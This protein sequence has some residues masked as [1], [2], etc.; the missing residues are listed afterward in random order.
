MA[1]IVFLLFMMTLFMNVKGL[2]QRWHFNF[3]NIG[4]NLAKSGWEAGYGGN[5][6]ITNE[7]SRSGNYSLKLTGRYRSWHSP[8]LQ[9]DRIFYEGGPGVYSFTVYVMVNNLDSTCS[10]YGRSIIRGYEDISLYMAT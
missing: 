2:N 7:H 3:D 1:L 9:L 8:A 10:K 6:S 4:F 5:V